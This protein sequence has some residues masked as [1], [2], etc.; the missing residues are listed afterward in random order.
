MTPDWAISP[1][2][3]KLRPSRLKTI[4]SN[5]NATIIIM[6]SGEGKADVVKS[7]LEESI[8]T[9]RPAS[10]FHNHSGCRL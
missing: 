8:D 2:L 9:E 6:A 3:S 10:A 1:F 4:S 5:P 7:A